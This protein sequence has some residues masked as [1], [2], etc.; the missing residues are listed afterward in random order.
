M[1]LDSFETLMPRD[2][3]DFHRPESSVIFVS[4]SFYMRAG[5][6]SSETGLKFTKNALTSS[7]TTDVLEALMFVVSAY[8][9]LFLAKA[10]REYKNSKASGLQSN[11]MTKIAA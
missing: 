9:K 3:L 8:V 5:L 2:Y 4:S 1:L 6:V 11:S 10:K 7:K